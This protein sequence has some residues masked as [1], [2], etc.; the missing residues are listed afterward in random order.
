[1]KRVRKETWQVAAL[2]AKMMQTSGQT[3]A[4][5]SDK[6]MRLL[7]GRSRLESS[8]RERIR[9]DAL[10]YGYLIHRLDAGSS[11]SGNVIVALSALAAAKTL[12]R[13]DTFT[14]EQWATIRNGTF[15]FDSLQDELLN[16]EE[17]GAEE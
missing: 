10:D 11:T 16:D 3:R 7:A 13:T 9:E 2:I 1:M 8:V 4:R 6:Q 15:D 14:D 5:I 12:K 17:D